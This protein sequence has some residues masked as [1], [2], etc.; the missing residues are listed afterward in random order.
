MNIELFIPRLVL[1]N[2]TV[3]EA[4]KGFFLLN[5]EH[6]NNLIPVSESSVSESSTSTT[7]I[8]IQLR[9]LVLYSGQNV[10]PSSVGNC[11]QTFII[12]AIAMST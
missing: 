7:L 3:V 4:P 1:F 11:L 8:I 2:F 10:H 9:F 6:V 5:N 12:I